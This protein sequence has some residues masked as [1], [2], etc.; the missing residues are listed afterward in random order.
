MGIS[1]I[2]RD[3]MGEGSGTLSVSRDYIIES[4]ITEAMEGCKF[5]LCIEFVQDGFER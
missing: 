1:V 5:L 4:D 2:I 3:V